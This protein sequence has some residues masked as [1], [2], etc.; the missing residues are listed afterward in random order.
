MAKGASQ[1]VPAA[2]ELGTG[3][4]EVGLPSGRAPARVRRFDTAGGV[5]GGQKLIDVENGVFL[6]TPNSGGMYG[7]EV[8]AG[9]VLKLE[10]KASKW[11]H[12]LDSVGVNAAHSIVFD[13][14]YFPVDAE[15]DAPIAFQRVLAQTAL[16]INGHTIRLGSSDTGVTLHHDGAQDGVASALANHCWLAPIGQTGCRNLVVHSYTDLPESRVYSADWLAAMKGRSVDI[17]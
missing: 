13:V 1:S 4:Y 9:K 6:K 8:M 17:Y 15:E 12:S 7:S 14:P 10:A 3:A 5:A 2:L 11:V 16:P